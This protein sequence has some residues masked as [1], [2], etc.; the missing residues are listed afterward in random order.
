[1]LRLWGT[2]LR[3]GA[4]WAGLLVLA[5]LVA[6]A[7]FSSSAKAEGT[8]QVI[9]RLNCDCSNGFVVVEPDGSGEKYIVEV[10]SPIDLP[11]GRYQY[12][13]YALGYMPWSDSMLLTGSVPT[14]EITVSFFDTDPRN[15]LVQFEQNELKRL[16]I[17]ELYGDDEV[18][19]LSVYDLLVLR[20]LEI[21]DGGEG[22]QEAMIHSLEGLQYA[23]HLQHLDLRRQNIASLE[24][25]EGLELLESVRLSGN[26]IESI[27]PL[28]DLPNLR[29]VEIE[30][31]KISS[32]PS[33]ASDR[34]ETLIL[35]NN[36]I[37]TVGDLSHL[38]QLHTL[39]LSHNLMEELPKLKSAALTAL[40]FSNN[41]LKDISSLS[42][43]DLPNLTE[44]HLDINELEDDDLEA[45]TR[46]EQLQTVHLEYNRLS[47]LTGFAANPENNLNWENMYLSENDITDAG[48][49][50]LPRF[51]NVKRLDVSGNR[52]TTLDPIKDMGSLVRLDAADNRI[53]VIPDFSVTGLKYLDLSGNLITDFVPLS[54]KNILD[55]GTLILRGN[56]IASLAFLS[57]GSYKFATLDI[58][59]NPLNSLGGIQTLANVQT[60]VLNDL[61]IRIIDDVLRLALNS[62]NLKHVELRLISKLESWQ[63]PNLEN[64]RSLVTANHTTHSNQLYWLGWDAVQTR[65][66]GAPVRH[67]IHSHLQW[68]KEPPFPDTALYLM[69]EKDGQRLAPDQVAVLPKF[70]SPRPDANGGYWVYPDEKESSANG[71]TYPVEFLFSEPGDYDIVWHLYAKLPLFGYEDYKFIAAFGKESLRVEAAA[72]K[73][74]PLSQVKGGSLVEFGG[75]TW[76][77]ADPENRILLL[78]N[79]PTSMDWAPGFKYTSDP[80]DIKLMFSPGSGGAVANWLNTVFLGQLPE[81]R[82]NWLQPTAPRVAYLKHDPNASLGATYYTD[83]SGNPEEYA[84]ENVLVRLLT[85]E[86]Y[87]AALDNG[88]LKPGDLRLDWPGNWYLMNPIEEQGGFSIA[89]VNSAGSLGSSSSYTYPP[90]VRPVVQLTEE[91][92]VKGGN[93][94]SEPYSL[95]TL[96]EPPE[97]DVLF[98]LQPA[99][100]TRGTVD[101]AMTVLVYG[102]NNGLESIFW[103]Q[104]PDG[105]EQE[106]QAEPEGMTG[107]FV[108]VFKARAT[109]GDNG[110]YQVTVRDTSGHERTQT[111]RVGNIYNQPPVIDWEPVYVS[112]GVEIQVAVEAAGEGNRVAAAKWAPGVYGID[113]FDELTEHVFYDSDAESFTFKV[114]GNGDYTIL[115]EDM[116]GN[117]T[118]EVVAF[119]FPSDLAVT[120]TTDQPFGFVG[121]DM[122]F[123][124]EVRHAQSV[125][126]TG[127]VSVRL[128]LPPD[129]TLQRLQ[130]EGWSCSLETAV[131]ETEVEELSAGAALPVLQAEVR[132]GG[133]P[134]LIPGA[135]RALLAPGSGDLNAFNNDSKL[136]VQ[137]YG[138]RFEPD[139]ATWSR[140]ASVTVTVTN[141]GQSGVLPSYTLYYL[142][143]DSAD[144]E[145]TEDWTPF[146]GGQTLT[147]SGV[148]GDWYLHVK[149]LDA[150]GRE[151]ARAVSKPYQLDQDPPALQ[152][153]RF[154][155]AET[156]APYMFGELTNQDVRL[157][158]WTEEDG[159]S[160]VAAVEASLDGGAWVPA[161]GFSVTAGGEHAVRLRVRD[162]AGNEFVTEPFI[163]RIV[164][165]KPRMDLTPS[166]NEFIYGEVTVHAAVYA[167]GTDLGNEIVI[168]KYAKGDR[169]ASYFADNGTVLTEPY[170]F[171]AEEN[172]TYTVYARDKA[173]NEQTQKI[174]ISNIVKER[175]VIMYLLSTQDPTNQPVAV[176]VTASVYGA[177]N[178]LARLGWK[179]LPD[180]EEKVLRTG[181]AQETNIP[182]LFTYT[183]TVVAEANGEYLITVVDAKGNETT[184]TVKIGNIFLTPPVIETEIKYSPGEANIHVEVIVEDGNGIASVKFAAGEWGTGNFD[185]LPSILPPGKTHTITVKENGKYTVLAKDL[186]GNVSAKVLNIDGIMK[187]LPGNDWYGNDWY[188]FDGSEPEQPGWPLIINGR[189][190]D[191]IA[192]VE[193]SREG[194]K[195]TVTVDREKL[196]NLLENE[197]DQP[198]IIVPVSAVEADQVVVL[199][200]AD[201][202][203]LME[204]K[205]AVLEIRTIN[206][207]YRLPAE[208]IGVDRLAAEFGEGADLSQIVIRLEV[209]RSDASM[210]QLIEDAAQSGNFEVVVP[211]VD[212]ALTAI[213]DGRTIEIDRFE[214]FIQREI[215]LPEGVNPSRITTAVVV[216]PDGTVRHVP[217]HVTQRD[218]VHYAVVN[219]LTNSTYALVRNR[220]E[221]ADVA[222]HWS[223]DAV[224]DM[225][226]RMVVNGTGEGTFSPDKSVTRAELAAI[227]VRALGLSDKGGTAPFKDVRESDWFAGAVA[228][229]HEY[230]LISGYEDGTFRPNETITRQEAVVILHRAMKWTGLSVDGTGIDRTLARF[231]DANEVADWAK[232]AFAALV[233]LG[234]VQGSDA[235]LNP[236]GKLT[237]AEAAALVHRLLKKAGWID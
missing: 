55:G 227:M 46:F 63:S 4:R 17:N 210:V 209:A 40:K 16:I 130:G 138:I 30:N 137:V 67:Q 175:P 53:E 222:H 194:A 118:A 27:E 70:G 170:R 223:R 235:G 140:E 110:E 87:R 122:A 173:G 196:A 200:T 214:A 236:Q 71:F 159:L 49:E 24:P 96:D 125:P 199:L 212:F 99:A 48:L 81:S 57:G 79:A 84:S 124:V 106:L 7:G 43:A 132:I 147:Q 231:A 9:F 197:G 189:Q 73:G 54:N 206:G 69:L 60:L 117:R 75:K 190:V 26:P 107:P 8:Q 202:I 180:G 164:H 56:Q 184:M 113:D 203:K 211:P 141:D 42:P 205:G 82:L 5:A 52:L 160:G 204:A 104:L 105:A 177:D 126:Y 121:G 92:I 149:V 109:V 181:A 131:C 68:D 156:G 64:L 38:N 21:P 37:E 14:I 86:E 10:G 133:E 198:E 143:K 32:V 188:S 157:E 62:S 80:L 221:F 228:K 13:G 172:G 47:N 142:W 161:T 129:W 59:Q 178:G 166:T 145:G 127:Q 187:E 152:E 195:L 39:D 61:P 34:M 144:L 65:V 97:P 208:R 66:H 217:T 191:S 94:A 163:I 150:D 176:T 220:K 174:E 12:T 41:K 20:T 135:F 112:D 134:A 230:G 89:V 115:A 165:E 2:V 153:V 83:Q 15:Q 215:P 213:H 22:W 154:V 18:Q 95:T 101:V 111:V 216:E 108:T 31:A 19:D 128:Q 155:K 119:N 183:A 192:V 45:L 114:T 186:A 74:T 218:G 162:M 100:P 168:V 229:A 28:K 148:N 123:S 76:V 151:V 226:S 36:R 33:F 90:K 102:R 1:M 29:V 232:D 25:L 58:S 171:V 77:L 51:A 185:S 11:L 224:N 120:A 3:T 158:G 201:T 179:L 88:W 35:N 103:K 234:L 50:L 98:E 72:A 207:N 139:G 91:V 93:G 136:D 44:V 78:A 167:G 116:F 6:L 146:A 23:R 237:R 182:G 225:A 219:S 193:T 233:H 85:F 169:D